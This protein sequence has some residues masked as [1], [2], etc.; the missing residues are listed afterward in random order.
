MEDVF[1]GKAE[2]LAFSDKI[3]AVISETSIVENGIMAKSK[4]Q[5]S[6]AAQRSAT[7]QRASATQKTGAQQSTTKQTVPAQKTAQSSSVGQKTSAAQR[8]EAQRSQQMANAERNRAKTRSNQNTSRGRKQASPAVSPFV[9]VGVTLLVIAAVVA[10]FFYISHNQSSGGSSSSIAINGR[11]PAPQQVVSQVTNVSPSTLQT[12]DV[13]NVSAPPVHVPSQ[14]PLNGPSGKPEYF[15]FGAEYCPYCA[16]QRWS[17]V[18]ALSRFGTFKNLSIT[19]SS[20]SDV[21]AST[22]T[23]SFY[24]SSYS[25][26]YIDFVSVETTTNQPNGNGYVTLETP[27]AEEQQIVSK[28]DA[29]PY[30]NQAGSIPFTDIGNQYL[31]IGPGFSPQVLQGKDWQQIADALSQPDSQIAQGVIGTANYLTAAICM[32]TNQQPGS[33]CQAAPIPAIETALNKASSFHATQFATAGNAPIAYVRR[34]D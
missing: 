32:T 29:P 31:M 17:M 33:V 14:P 13:G 16:A 12:V 9:W 26:S 3:G 30:T 23:F 5:K 15:Y 20:A 4:S 6:S 2:V 21:Y 22:P 8:R 11:K 25:S 34:E 28:Y 27:T 18:V 7:S 10:L 24:G 19:T 1:S